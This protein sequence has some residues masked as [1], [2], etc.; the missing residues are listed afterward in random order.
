VEWGQQ[1]QWRRRLRVGAPVT[2]RAKSSQ[3]TPFATI[4]VNDSLLIYTVH[5]FSS[6]E[7]IK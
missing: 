5:F 6:S 3:I 1:R 2:I 7:E 4:A